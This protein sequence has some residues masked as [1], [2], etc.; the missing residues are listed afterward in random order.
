MSDSKPIPL[1]RAIVF[2]GVNVPTPVPA[3]FHAAIAWLKAKYHGQPHHP[4]VLAAFKNDIDYLRRRGCFDDAR[5]VHMDRIEAGASP[6][7]SAL[8]I[9]MESSDPS[10][11]PIVLPLWDPS[12][13]PA[14]YGVHWMGPMRDS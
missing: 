1:P 7:N 11:E 14:V 9:S 10:H 8:T 12:D 13:P 4:Q 6:I 5:R 3:N 2:S